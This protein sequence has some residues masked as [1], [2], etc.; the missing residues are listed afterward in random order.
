MM[1]LTYSLLLH[2]MEKIDK[3]K[4][5][6][7]IK[8]KSTIK[9]NAFIQVHKDSQ[10]DKIDV[11]I[12]DTKD[13]SKFYPQQKIMRWDNEVN[14]SVRLIH[15][16]KKP[17]VTTEKDKIV[18]EGDKVKAEI[19]QLTDGEGGQEFEI[20]LKEKPKSNVVQFT[21][22][23]KGVDYF[24]QPE[25][26]DSEVSEMAEREGITLLEAK[27]KCRPENVV[28]S[29]V[30]YAS[31][32]KI[33][34]VG[35]KEYKCG[36]VGHIY[37]PKIIDSKGTEVWG[38]LHIENG[39]LSVTIPQEFLDKAV[40][41]VRHAAGLTF[42]YTSVGGTL[43]DG[44]SS[45]GQLMANNQTYSPAS[46]GTVS[47]I[48]V[49]GKKNT[50]GQVRM[51]LY[52]GTSLVSG[53]DTGASLLPASVGWLSLNCS[54]SVLAA[55]AYYIALNMQY[56]Y[57]FY[58]D[59]LAS[60]IPKRVSNIA[61][62]NS[63]PNPITWANYFKNQTTSIYATYTSA[64]SEV[65]PT[66]TTQAVTSILQTTAT[67]N[68]NV[69][70]D[71]GATITERGVCWNTSTNPTTSNSKA[72]SAGTTGVYTVSMTGL[73][74]NTLYYVKSYAIN[75]VG[76]SYGSEVTFTTLDYPKTTG[77]SSITGINTITF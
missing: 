54:A 73:S 22:V 36:K 69:T 12:G 44:S 10:K 25:L 8:D 13:A 31:E 51:G 14:C 35:G 7:E 58:Y 43:M 50:D 19:Y 34:Y 75:S 66:V 24:Y 15:D 70:A 11:E 21:L 59:A 32:N 33:N 38:N 49:Y 17:K 5:S 53:S 3:T 62:A 1:E 72:T 64:P 41:P 9:N 23:D 37:R 2:N 45:T 56:N 47:S 40:Y 26:E 18:W 68:G 29:Y 77:I 60:N 57:H 76:T 42:G 27:R 71:G 63:L 61:V 6:K 65:A 67:G 48:S 28:G 30:V 74:A 39:I 4:L 55:K 20:T 16:E 52:D 46:D